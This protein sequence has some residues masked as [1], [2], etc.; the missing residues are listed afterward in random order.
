MDY[1]S[2]FISIKIF[3]YKISNNRFNR[4]APFVTEFATRCARLRKLRANPLRGTGL[5]VKRMLDGP[6]GRRKKK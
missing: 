5:P 6:C 1:F 3:E 2:E 4:T